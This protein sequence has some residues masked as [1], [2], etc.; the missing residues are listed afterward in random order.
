M[1]IFIKDVKGLSIPKQATENDAAYDI[2]ATTPPIIFGTKIQRSMDYMDMWSKITFIEYGTNVFIA[3]EDKN[4]H[5]L[6]HPRSS[7]SKTNL[8]LANSVGLVDNGYRGQL[9]CRFKYIS[10]P[11][12]LIVL[13]E[14][15]GTRVYTIVNLDNIYKEGDKIIQI[16]AS[17]NIPID[18]ELVYD[19][20]KTQR[21]EGGFGSSGI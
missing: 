11:E 15:G 19:L 10:Q 8:I 13:N 4:F 17:Q 2:I 21:G 16:K 18:F 12:D 1:K 6:L 5:T 20:N 9:Y 14:A 7:I 3:P